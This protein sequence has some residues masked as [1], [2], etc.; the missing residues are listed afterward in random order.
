MREASSAG[1]RCHAPSARQP[2]ACPASTRKARR[3]SPPRLRPPPGPR[4]LPCACH[5][6]CRCVP[7][8]APRRP[9]R[10]FSGMTGSGLRGMC[11][12][13]TGVQLVRHQHFADQRR[14]L[15][16]IFRL[17]LVLAG[18]H[19]PPLALGAARPC[20]VG[21]RCSPP[22]SAVPSTT[23]P[24]ASR[25]LDRQ[26]LGAVAMPD[27]AAVAEQPAVGQLPQRP[28]ALGAGEPQQAIR[29]RWPRRRL[30]PARSRRIPSG[31]KDFCERS[32]R[33]SVTSR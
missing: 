19:L 24:P 12:I 21:S 11:L 29:R 1:S 33:T 26:P 31:D 28:A 20:G 18:Q 4:I 9:R 15:F 32:T 23:P 13:G 8:P 5:C 14:P 7:A 27:V 10:P 3:T 30:A 6:R 17:P 16:R 25:V 22:A 2:C